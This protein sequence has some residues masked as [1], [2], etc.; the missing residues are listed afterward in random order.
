MPRKLKKRASYGGGS[1]VEVRPGIWRIRL[2]TGSGR[3]CR[4]VKGNEAQAIRV[5][6][7]IVAQLSA[8]EYVAPSYM[9]FREYLDEWLENV[10]RA[11]APNTYKLYRRTSDKW[12]IP[13]LG[14]IQIQKLRPSDI[15][16]FFSSLPADFSVSYKQ[17]MYLIINGALKAAKNEGV[18]KDNPAPRTAGKP[19]VDKNL[20]ASLADA[21]CWTEADARKFLVMAKSYGPRQAALYSLALDAGLRKGE[22]CALRWP[23]V[24][25]QEGTIHVKASLSYV[26]GKMVLGPTKTRQARTL[27][28][29]PETLDLLKRWSIAQ[30]EWKA[31]NP[32]WQEQGLIFT[33]KDG[34]PLQYNTLGERE[35]DKIQEAAKVKRITF[36]GLRHTCATLMLKNRVPLKYVQERLG[37]RDPLTTIRTYAHV[38][39]SGEKDMIETIRKALG[40][41]AES[42]PPPDGWKN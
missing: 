3:I 41:I 26:E 1:V 27:V 28:I 11:M 24:N 39:P 23:S 33:K 4:T 19:R 42:T 17:Q 6:N 30:A 29:S 7:E 15:R 5:R 38:L 34:T 13:A 8:G 22:I 35:F 36:H 9:P 31:A 25:W 10:A 20:A 18:I 2:R 14:H 12:I 16:E 21:N 32:E 40:F 37:H